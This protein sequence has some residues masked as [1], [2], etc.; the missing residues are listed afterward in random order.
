MF[1][2]VIK[3]HLYLIN[4]CMT[5]LVRFITLRLFQTLVSACANRI[6][7]NLALPNLLK[8]ASF[9]LKNGTDCNVNKDV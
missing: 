1:N 6:A 8:N 4:S 3:P 2:T 5:R 7:L 9:I